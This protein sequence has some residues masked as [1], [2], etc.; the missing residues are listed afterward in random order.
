MSGG[1]SEASAGRGST[2]AL[3][4]TDEDFT[5]DGAVA[6]GFVGKNSEIA[7]LQRLQQE[8]GYGLI[9]AKQDAANF[10]ERNGGATPSNNK[11][12]QNAAALPEAEEGFFVQDSSYHLDDLPIDTFAVVDPHEMPPLETAQELFSSYITRCHP[13]FPVIGKK[14]LT[15]QFDKFIS[16]R[17]RDPPAQWLAIVNLIFAVSAKYAHLVQADWKGD[18]RDHLIYFSRARM[19]AMNGDSIFQHTDLQ[20]VQVL[21]L[22]SFYFLCTGQINR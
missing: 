18:D 10:V 11:V 21:G 19:L 1:E 2:G 16:G 3:D 14:V 12:S 7:W 13:T 5:R 4:R 8:N 20:Q 9:N 22:M 6:T 17:I 15:G